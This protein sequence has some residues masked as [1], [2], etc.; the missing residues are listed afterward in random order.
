MKKELPSYE[1]LR[2]PDIVRKATYQLEGLILVTGKANSG[3]TT[4]L[5]ALIKDINE[6]QN[7]KIMILERLETY[8]HVS[9]KS[10]IVQKQ[11]GAGGDCESY[12]EGIKNSLK[13]D[14]DII[15]VEE[16]S[17]KET[18]NAVI[19]ATETGCLVIGTLYTKSCTE[20][21]E[22][23]FNFYD[24]SE[25][26]NIKYIIASILK[27]VMSQ[28]L[29]KGR[30]GKL[31]LL[32]EILVVDSNTSKMLCRENINISELE[33]SIQ[34]NI[35]KGNISLICSIAKLFMED[36]I[37]LEQAKEQIKEENFEMLNKTIMQLKIK[38][39][40]ECKAKK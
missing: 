6:N 14:C 30:N 17:D 32:P 39:D 13:E 24:S 33:D 1:T 15:I 38:K 40:K 2:I 18:M 7:K 28:R 29:L 27:L 21:I 12:G 5:N 36:I 16:I 22:K 26:T 3:K 10:M 37:T 8:K 20:A 19:E 9:S 35:E 25:R 31:V 34:N 4:T 11:V 23:I